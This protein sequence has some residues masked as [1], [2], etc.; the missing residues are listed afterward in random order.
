MTQEEKRLI[1]LW[2]ENILNMAEDGTFTD[3]KDQLTNIKTYAK[4]VKDFT[5][6]YWDKPYKWK[7]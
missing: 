3:V 1:C 2:L 5:E 7:D 6:K 4:E